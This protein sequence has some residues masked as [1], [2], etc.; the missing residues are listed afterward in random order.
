[1]API[2]EHQP[3]PPDSV[4]KLAKRID[5]RGYQTF[6]GRVGP[7]MRGIFER[8]VP[9]G[10]WRDFDVVRDWAERVADSVQPVGVRI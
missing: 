4:A 8:W 5:A 1:V 10:D 9:K 3:D 7:D 2:L 6:G